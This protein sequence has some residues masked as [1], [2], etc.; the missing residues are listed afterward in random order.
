MKNLLRL[1]ITEIFLGICFSNLCAAQCI[2]YA[3]D[4]A[5]DRIARNICPTP[6]AGPSSPRLAILETSV[7]TNG[8]ASLE[9]FPNPT[10]GFILLKTSVFN[11]ESRILFTDVLGRVIREGYLQ[12]GRLDISEL[13][14]GRYFIRVSDKEK[15]RVVTVVKE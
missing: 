15:F 7:N 12:E 3:Y 13:Q 1:K 8:N 4:A 14:P 9:V 10:T 5:G 6:I 11:P 2:Q